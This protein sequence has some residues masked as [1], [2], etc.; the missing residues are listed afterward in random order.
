MM[1]G[2]SKSRPSVFG[3]Q[4]PGAMPCGKK[5]AVNRVFGFAAVSRSSV[6]AG[7]IASSSGRARVTP[8]PYKKVRRGKCFFAMN[9]SVFLLAIGGRLLRPVFRQFHV[10]LESAALHDSEDQRREA[11][12]FGGGVPDDG[13]NQRHVVVLDAAA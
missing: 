7:S 6:C 9:I 10:V 12:V 1:N 11:V 2:N 5:I 4:C 8:V 3:T 13:T